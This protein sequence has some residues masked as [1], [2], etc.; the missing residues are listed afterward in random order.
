MS[1]SSSDLVYQVASSSVLPATQRYEHWL[2]PLL[3]NF[4]AAA[5]NARQCQDFQGHVTSLVLGTREL[6]DAQ[7][8]DFHGAHSR[9]GIQK[10][11]TDKLAL[12]YVMHGSVVCQY[13]N[14]ID[15]AIHQGQF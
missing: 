14:D 4:E 8:D 6:H 7:L 10:H 3:S 1:A 15:T 5:P 2:R 11:D 13:E 12:I 9:R